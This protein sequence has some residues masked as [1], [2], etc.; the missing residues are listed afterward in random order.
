M[1]YASSTHVKPTPKPVRVRK[2]LLRPAW[3]QHPE[4]KQIARLRE[5][6]VKGDYEI[7]YDNPI[8]PSVGGGK[9]MLTNLLH[10]EGFKHHFKPRKPREKK[11]AQKP[12]KDGWPR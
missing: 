2:K 12:H 3:Y 1:R 8:R 10:N 7:V 5:V 9:D 4:T 6:W 11:G